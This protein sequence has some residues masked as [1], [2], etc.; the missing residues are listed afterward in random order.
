MSTEECVRPYSAFVRFLASLGM[1]RLFFTSNL[2]TTSGVLLAR[3]E[4][5]R[6]VRVF[7]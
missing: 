3:R 1:T 6:A 7:P 2:R 5:W 4:L